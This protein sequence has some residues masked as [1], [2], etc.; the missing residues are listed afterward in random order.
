MSTNKT[1]IMVFG[2]SYLVTVIITA[3]FALFD[4]DVHHD[5][6]MLATAIGVAE[7]K[8][9]FSEV[10]TQY[11]PLTAWYQSLWVFFMQDHPAL[12][13]RLSHLLLIIGSS[14][15]MGALG[16]V[17]PKGTG[18][19]PSITWP[20]SLFWLLLNDVFYGVAMI[21]WP[22]M[23]ATF[24]IVVANY[25]I[26]RG[27]QGEHAELRE[28]WPVFFAGF[29][30]GVLPFARQSVG[31]VVII[32]LVFIAFSATRSQTISGGFLRLGLSGVCSGGLVVFIP[33]ALARSL[34]EWWSQSVLWA[35][36]YISSSNFLSTI[37]PLGQLS[38]EFGPFIALSLGAILMALRWT[39]FQLPGTMMVTLSILSLLTDFPSFDGR[40]EGSPHGFGE[41]L[42]NEWT[43]TVLTINVR[44]L[45]L[46]FGATLFA[47]AYYLVTLIV[48]FLRKQYNDVQFSRGVLLVFALGSL[49]Q[50]VP[51]TDSR[52]IWWAMPSLIIVSA[53]SLE[54]LSRK[55]PALKT[56]MPT[57]AVW[58]SALVLTAGANLFLVERMPY[59]SSTIASGLFSRS[60]NVERLE[61]ETDFMSSTSGN[62]KIFLVFDGHL[63]VL[64]GTFN[65]SDA[66]FVDW[67]PL[68][69][70]ESRLREGSE[71]VTDK[72][73][74]QFL[75]AASIRY[76]L[77]NSSE[78]IDLYVVRVLE[79]PR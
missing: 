53:G 25:L 7:G 37:G 71:V 19:T 57:I 51:I 69:P 42:R 2:A 76:E 10:F 15:M 70:L 48:L 23:L 9:L 13:L 29:A 54:S 55:I 49:S 59:P 8:H 67:G 35:F 77:T 18:L 43:S 33:L 4:F 21:P 6:Y 74:L 11:G 40:G 68:P 28:K 16:R 38:F 26:F 73:G 24:L 64:N 3:H 39:K 36:T 44:F 60:G 5:G 22:S 47:L 31:L 72:D 78:R 65:S 14:L 45:H 32:L 63:S 56:V 50:T 61:A 52:H 41:A 1:V 12:A 75:A 30:I 62:P 20:I 17:A 27:L 34:D 79:D 46:V 66:Y 58:L